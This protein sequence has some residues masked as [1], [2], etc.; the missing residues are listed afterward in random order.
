MSFPDIDSIEGVLSTRPSC[1]FV[2]ARITPEPCSVCPVVLMVV[3]KAETAAAEEEEVG[4]VGFVVM[5]EVVVV[6]EDEEEEDSS[7]LTRYCSLM[8]AIPAPGWYII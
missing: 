1:S 4:V 6:D 5:V 8:C 3:E 7:C 2:R